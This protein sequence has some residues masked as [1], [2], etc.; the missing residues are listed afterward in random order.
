MRFSFYTDL[1]LTDNSPCHRIDNYVQTLCNKLKTVYDLSVAND[2][3]CVTFGGDF[4]DRHKIYDYDVIQHAISVIKN[5]GIQTY[6]CIGEH[7]L[8]GHSPETYTK[9]TLSFL[10]NFTP[11]MNLLW[12]PVH[13]PNG[14]SFYGKHEWEKMDDFANIQLDKS[15]YNVL[16]CHELLYNKKMPYS[17]TNTADLDLPFD[18]VCS[19]DLHCGFE[20]HQVKNTWYCNPG[21]LARRTTADI[22]RMPKMLIVDVRKGYDPIIRGQVLPGFKPGKE[23]LEIGLSE[24]IRNFESKIDM[25]KFVQSFETL[26]HEKMD[27]YDLF[28]EFKAKN[29]VKN[30]IIAYI[31]SLKSNRKT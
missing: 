28:D 23:V 22:R 15:R 21:S 6:A 7:D 3:E 18:L 31:Q 1:H 30:D 26:E 12:K 24:T 29:L 20:P 2:C 19:G 13:L 14:V 11:N 8:Y 9:S 25:T 27:I 4:F 10:C 5:S 17:I 16:L